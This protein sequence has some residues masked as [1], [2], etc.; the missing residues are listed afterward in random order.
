MCLKVLSFCF[1]VWL[2]LQGGATAD[3]N[4]RIN[5]CEAVGGGSCVFDIMR[6]LA[7][8]GNGG[9]QTPR[10]R[11]GVFRSQNDGDTTD[12]SV[13]YEGV[14]LRFI[15][16]AGYRYAVCPDNYHCKLS[17]DGFDRVSIISPTELNRTYQSFGGGIYSETWVLN[18]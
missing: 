18:R 15:V 14:T 12:V 3:I 13:S 8:S 10:L 9:N 5:N 1:L 4:D 11:S 17:A 16:F 2:H 6:E 7:T